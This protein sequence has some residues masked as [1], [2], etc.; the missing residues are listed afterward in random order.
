MSLQFTRKISSECFCST[1]KTYPE[2]WYDLEKVFGVQLVVPSTEES[3]PTVTT[4]ETSTA[5]SAL[6]S[7]VIIGMR[8]S[9]KTTS[10]KKLA[11]ALG[12]KFYDVDHVFEESKKMTVKEF[13]ASE[14]GSWPEFRRLEAEILTKLVEE[15]STGAVISTGM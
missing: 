5:A 11:E 7:V 3:T 10:G 12:F 1:D 15:N 2:F 13:V 14:G 8:G 6:P 9:G 4:T